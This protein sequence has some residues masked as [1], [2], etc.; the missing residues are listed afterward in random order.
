MSWK[1]ITAREYG[2]QYSEMQIRSLTDKAADFLPYT[3]YNQLIIPEE[4]NECF[5]IKEED[6]N[7][8][9][10]SL[11]E[12]FASSLELLGKFEEKF[13]KLGTE[14]LKK[15]E[16]ISLLD[17]ENLSNK[18]L[19]NL[20]LDYQQ[21]LLLY[22]VFVWAGFILNNFVA[23]KANNILEKYL[24]NLDSDRK[25]Q[26]IKSIFRPI[27]KAAALEFQGEAIE[28]MKNPFPQEL[29]KLYLKY[30]WMPCLDIHNTP[31][32]E[33]EFKKEIN[34]F[35]LENNKTQEII[36]GKDIKL[37]IKDKPF[38]EMARRFAYIM[39]ARDDFRRKGVFN[40][41]SF[42]REI[43]KRMGL[44]IEETSYLQEKEIVDL[45][46]Q[47]KTVSRDVIEQ[48]QKGFALYFDESREIICVEGENSIEQVR[49]EF[50]IE[51]LREGSSQIKGLVASR[52]RA[53]GSVAVVKGIGQLDNIRKGNVMVA[54][55][56][57]PD[58]LPAMKR[59]VAI[60]T[61]EGGM[62]CHAAITSRELSIPCI[63]GTK[64]A[65]KILKEGDLVEV[66]AE[67]GIVKILEKAK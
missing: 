36:E 15:T 47:D 49:K 59:A 52:G 21:K 29:H 6:W 17:L 24:L 41:R 30:R 32:S 39:D 55:T 48:R 64:T 12:K 45:L 9:V 26:I 61:D 67:K 19:Y 10:K 5:Y 38:T 13:L 11:Y 35:E 31:W 34:S 18:E 1:K 3:S 44:T 20:Y 54:I 60:I 53:K 66:D 62:S 23:E 65:T 25:S 37:N 16:E 63:V 50:G 51:R 57:H 46:I 58:Y 8:L 7:N 22:C 14:Y 33:K 28:F 42:F 40:A 43:G 2:V 27:K 56:T 4:N